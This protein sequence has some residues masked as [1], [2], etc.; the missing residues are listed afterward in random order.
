MNDI[1]RAAETDARREWSAMSD[2]E[3]FAALKAACSAAC[4]LRPENVRRAGGC[5]PVELIGDAWIRA[6]TRISAGDGR[7]LQQLLLFAALDALR[8]EARTNAH[9]VGGSAQGLADGDTAEGDAAEGDAADMSGTAR[10]VEDAGEILDAI[11]AAARDDID[12]AIIR[13]A[14]AGIA[15]NEIAAAVGMSG[16]TVRKRLN[17]IRARITAYTADTGAAMP[18]HR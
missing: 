6:E 1:N 9:S 7:A 12:R 10:P 16:Q 11:R 3:K 13:A 4:A 2:E 18:A 14:A 17:A 5:K 15:S 8:K